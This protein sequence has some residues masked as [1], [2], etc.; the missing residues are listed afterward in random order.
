PNGVV[1]NYYM[2][3][4]SDSTKLSID[5]LDKNKKLIKSYSTTSKEIKI[6]LNKGMNQFEWDMFYPEAERVEGLI[7][8][9]GAISG[10]KADPGNYFAKFKSGNDSSLAAFT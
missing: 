10:P 9:N 4:V 1:M 7:L 2:K 3:D 8:W 5:I 6:E